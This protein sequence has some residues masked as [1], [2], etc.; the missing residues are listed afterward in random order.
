ML[1]VNC[2]LRIANAIAIANADSPGLMFTVAEKY[3]ASPR[4]SN[5]LL[6]WKYDLLA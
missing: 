4:F 5:Q 2:E 6:T 1:I 3:I